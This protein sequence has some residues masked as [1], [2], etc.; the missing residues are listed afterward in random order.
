M[1]DVTFSCRDKESCV[2]ECQDVLA[3]RTAEYFAKSESSL[4]SII[5]LLR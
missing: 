2:T 5:D 1:L 3:K 4:T